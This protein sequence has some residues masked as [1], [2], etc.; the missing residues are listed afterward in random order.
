MFVQDLLIRVEE[1][2]K[3]M[4][5]WVDNDVECHKVWIISL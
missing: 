3:V 1:A 2:M 4:R 5:S